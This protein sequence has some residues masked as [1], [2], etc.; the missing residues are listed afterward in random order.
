[1]ALRKIKRPTGPGANRG[2][3]KAGVMAFASTADRKAAVGRRQAA[4]AETIEARLDRKA[5][6]ADTQTY[7]TPSLGQLSPEQRH[8][9]LYRD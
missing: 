6:V 4:Q 2:G 3:K 8:K 7:T 1:M 5:A 9:L